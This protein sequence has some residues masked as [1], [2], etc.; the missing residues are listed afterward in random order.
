MSKLII[1]AAGSGKTETLVNMAL[2]EKGP[3]LITTYTDNN[4][5]E[6]KSRFY[7]KRGCIPQNVVVLPWYTFMLTY[8]V[9]PYQD[10]KFK[11]DIR[12]VCIT[13]GGSAKYIKKG[14]KEFYFTDDNAIYADKIAQLLLDLNEEIDGHVIANIRT[15]FP[16][17]YID[18]VQDLTGYD[19]ELIQ[20]LI[21]GGIDVTCVGDPRQGVFITCKGNK[22]RKYFRSKMMDFFSTRLPLLEVDQESLKT[23]YRCVGDICQLSDQLFPE[24]THVVSGNHQ[25][26]KRNGCY[27]VRPSDIEEYQLE[28][29]AMQLRHSIRSK[30]NEKYL[31]NSF[32]LVK[33]KT[34][35]HVL[36]YPTEPMINWLIHKREIE[37]PETKA[38]LYVAI[39]RARYS[40][41][42]VYDYPDSFS[43]DLIKLYK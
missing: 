23:N 19:Q 3:V 29:P 28:C 43:H 20:S 39:T 31:T 38:K 37:S 25:K 32:G 6:V 41:G 24:F 26:S 4:V 14:K 33:G 10:L 9:K 35:S 36:I 16:V 1:A 22:N 30:V 27:F 12:G 18:E 40:V 17:I 11:N 2:S 34:F 8:G 5:D 15:L 7:E 21:D 13:G 42:F